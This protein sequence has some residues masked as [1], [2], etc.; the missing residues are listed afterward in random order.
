MD[1]IFMIS[2]NIKLSDTHKQHKL[3]LNLANKLIS[4]RSNKYQSV[5]IGLQDVPSTSFS[6][7][8]RKF[9][10]DSI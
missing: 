9:L 3:M 8:S 6:K 7:V 10:K 4:K 5:K 1:V 2:K